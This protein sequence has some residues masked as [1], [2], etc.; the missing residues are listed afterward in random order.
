MKS[1]DKVRIAGDFLRHAG[2]DSPMKDAELIVAHCLGV[3]RINLYRD[4]PDIGGEALSLIESCLRRRAD[5]EPLQ[6]ILGYVEFFSLRINIGPGVLIPR[7]E[8]ELLVE[9]AIKEIATLRLQNT[10]ISILDL[11]TGSGCI[12]LALAKV[13][14]D[15]EV[16]GTDLSETAIHYAKDNARH[17]GIGNA[18]FLHGSLFEP[19]ASAHES[20]S[21]A[22]AFDLI[23]S[24]PPY[25]KTDDIVMLQ[26]EIRNYEPIHALNGGADGLSFYRKIIPE[27]KK[28]L[29]KNGFLMF[30]IGSGQADAVKD[31]AMAEGYM[32]ISLRKDFADIDRVITIR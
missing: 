10:R 11:C 30:E 19:F 23:I 1:I 32:H 28:Y 21:P 26:P 20:D 24:N 17:N 22:L 4:N 14:A 18:I 15:A 2:I 13:F 9:E 8:T 16:Y 31:I 29:K 27:A 3:N 12:A 25:V 7:A 6:Y 5:R